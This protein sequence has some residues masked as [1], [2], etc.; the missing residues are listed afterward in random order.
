[1]SYVSAWQRLSDALAAVV[2]A[3]GQSNEEAKG[4]ISR[5]VADGVIKFR[6]QLKRHTTRPIRW[7]VVVSGDDFQL[8]AQLSPADFDWEQSRP[9]NPWFLR[10]ERSRNPG[11]WELAWIELST[12]DA[13]T[14]LCGPTVEAVP[15]RR[16]T[17]PTRARP[18]FDREKNTLN[19]LY[20][21]GVPS[22]AELPNFQL[23][24]RVK[25][26]ISE[27]RQPPIS[28]DTILRAAGRHN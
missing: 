14:V 18:A 2:A 16:Q 9:I 19:A 11:Y 1:M 15:P 28:D 24:Y 3:T 5:A 7:D 6:A 27:L 8:P 26:K 10:R 21:E 23:C 22:Q 13:Q 12:A 25:Q 17:R 20:P 4:D